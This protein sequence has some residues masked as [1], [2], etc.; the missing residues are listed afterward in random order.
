M[1]N[2]PATIVVS[3]VNGLCG[4]GPLSDPLVITV[5]ALPSDPGTVSGPVST[6]RSTAGVIYSILPVNGATSYAW[7]V[8]SGATI[9]GSSTGNSISVNFGASASDGNV[10]V[11]A[12]NGCGASFNTSQLA[13]SLFDRPSPMITGQTTVN[14]NDTVT[15]TADIGMSDYSWSV[16]SGGEI[17]AGGSS[18]DDFVAIHWTN[19][20]VQTI[21]LDYTNT[22]GCQAL[23]PT[24]L[25]ITVNLLPGEPSKPTGDTVLCQ[26]SGDTPYITTGATGAVTYIWSLNPAAAGSISGSGLTG[27]VTWNPTWY[28]TAVITVAGHN[29]SGDGPSSDPITVTLYKKPDTGPAY[30]IPNDFD[31]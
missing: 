2:G 6:C 1:F 17:T 22:N 18:S 9:T 11:Q 10:T 12:L 3:G 20:G 13:I 21:S 24:V 5:N 23:S 7:T 16:S 31:F 19:G 30:Y 25:N 15:Y 14:L 26:G 29:G 4:E 28:G 27:T 8:P